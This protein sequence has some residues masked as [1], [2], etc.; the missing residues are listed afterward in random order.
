LD[1]LIIECSNYLNLNSRLGKVISKLGTIKEKRDIKEEKKKKKTIDEYFIIEDESIEESKTQTKSQIDINPPE[2]FYDKKI[3]DL[4]RINKEGLYNS[5]CGK[6]YLQKSNLLNH[7]LKCPECSNLLLRRRTEGNYYCTCGKIYRYSYQL[8][9]HIKICREFK[10]NIKLIIYEDKLENPRDDDNPPKEK[11]T[12]QLVKSDFEE[13]WAFVK[14]SIHPGKILFTLKEKKPNEIVNV[15]DIGITVKT[16]GSPQI[17]TKELIKKAWLNLVKDGVLYQKEHGK[18]TYHSSFIMALFSQ[19]DFVNVIR[20][21]PLCVKLDSAKLKYYE[22]TDESYEKVPKANSGD[23]KAWF[24]IGNVLG[25]LEFYKDAIECYE[26][27]LEIDPRFKKAWF[28]KEKCFWLNKAFIFFNEEKY[29]KAIE[30]YD[31]VLE[32]DPGYKKAWHNKT[33]ALEKL[34]KS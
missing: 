34:K 33:M 27:A 2:S 28:N 6:S 18:S 22:E 9:N 29:E 13:F 20:E 26:K 23:K 12:Y 24:N 16:E 14:N 5:S 31:R 1:N 11:K 25:D 17:I 7:Y 21:G 4:F 19:F 3:K 30:C 10:E 32:I 15:G 8:S